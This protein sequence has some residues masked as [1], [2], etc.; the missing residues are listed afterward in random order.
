MKKNQSFKTI[1]FTLIAFILL[2]SIGFLYKYQTRT[3]YNEKIAIGNT[4]GNLNNKGL[5]CEYNGTV[6]FSNPYDE[7]R[8]YSMTTDGT[9]IKKL[10]DDKASYINATGKYVYYIKDNSNSDF[11][12]NAFKG[13]MFGIRR[14]DTSGSNSKS[15]SSDIISSMSL[16]GNHIY[17]LGYKDDQGVYSLQKVSIDGKEYKEVLKETVTPLSVYN[18]K[19]YFNGTTKDH[20][21][22][23]LNPG[24]DKVETVYYGNTF[25]PVVE[26][27]Y[28]YFLDMEK[29]YALAKVSL[30]TGEKIIL[31]SERIDAYNVY[32]NYIYYQV[33]DATNPRFCRMN[34]DGRDEE[35]IAVGNFSDISI[36][37]S[38]VYFKAFGTDYPIYKTPTL[39]AIEVT[40]FEL[41]SF[42]SK[43]N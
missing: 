23:S 8:L 41:A 25:M 16:S 31:T 43:E 11:V 15:L 12:S 36:T 3:I 34:I 20:N 14:I 9:D 13:N 30:S 17:Y 40:T 29:N 38:Y 37:S 26:D 2:G 10:S 22:Y 28:L 4:G 39:G 33:N 7:G 1:L 27:D 42:T 24:N 6:F 19:L 5:F 21:I 32:G 18:G 35:T